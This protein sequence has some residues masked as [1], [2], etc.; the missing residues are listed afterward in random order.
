MP[1]EQIEA[2]LAQA[3]EFEE[4]DDGSEVVVWAENWNI[5]EAFTHCRWRKQVVLTGT[6]AITTYD[7]IES[8]ELL[9]VC[10]LL[11]IPQA[12]RRDVSWGVQVMAAT[13]LPHLNEAH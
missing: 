13:A 6:G 3:G 8:T 12:Q 1:E 4:E 11:G 10:E 2:A 9:S 7:C 5:V